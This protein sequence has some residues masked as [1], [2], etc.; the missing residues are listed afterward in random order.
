M[1]TKLVMPEEFG[2]S[3]EKEKCIQYIIKQQDVSREEAEQIYDEICLMETKDT[4]D[5]LVA[6]GLVE[7]VDYD[8][9]GEPRFG[10]TELGKKIMNKSNEN[11]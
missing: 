11:N 1:K 7:I 10:L 3:L 5:Q 8:E 4:V 2:A 6:E 9:T